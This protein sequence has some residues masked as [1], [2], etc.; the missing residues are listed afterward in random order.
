MFDTT[1][2]WVALCGVITAFVDIG[3]PDDIGLFYMI[4]II[5]VISLVYKML[6]KERDSKYMRMTSK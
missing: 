5:P 3:A 4:L 6:I 1:L 2:F